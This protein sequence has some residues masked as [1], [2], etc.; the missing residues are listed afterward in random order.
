M[1]ASVFGLVDIVQQLIVLNANV[2]QQTN[3]GYTA[4]MFAAEFGYDEIVQLLIQADANIFLMHDDENALMKAVK[5]SHCSIVKLLIEHGMK[6]SRQEKLHILHVPC[7]SAESIYEILD[8]DLQLNSALIYALDSRYIYDEAT[9]KQ[10]IKLLIHAGADLKNTADGG[11]GNIALFLAVEK[12]YQDIVQELI[13]YRADINSKYYNLTALMVAIEQNN[14]HMAQFLLE[15]GANI[16]LKIGW[17]KTALSIAYK[18]KNK[19]AIRLLLKT[20]EKIKTTNCI[21]RCILFFLKNIN[22]NN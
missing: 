13:V 7:G 10:I 3:N 6:K 5:A 11:I 16:A 15:S 20:Y 2:N 4:L 14:L 8:D 17:F 19:N 18:K 12:N 21:D 22:F 9:N 1:F